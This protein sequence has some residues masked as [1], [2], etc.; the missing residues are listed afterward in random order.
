[1]STIRQQVLD[2]LLTRLGAIS[3]GATYATS[4]GS[5]VK[6]NPDKSTEP[7]GDDQT[8]AAIVRETGGTEQAG[9]ASENFGVIDL[10]ISV[11]SAAVKA[12]GPQ[13]T[14]KDAHADLVK[15]IGVDKTFG[16]LADDC[17]LGEVD[18]ATV[19]KGKVACTVTQKLRLHYRT[20]RWDP[21]AA[22]A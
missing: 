10:E 7:L 5:T 1:M 22:P 8:L 4:V 20:A 14:A 21:T 12:D 11:L 6:L 3:A 19:A 13:N 17:V 15:S 9:M 2:A 16:G 18:F